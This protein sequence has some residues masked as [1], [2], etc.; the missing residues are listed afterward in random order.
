[1]EDSTTS[2][3]IVIRTMDVQ[4][5]MVGLNE[6]G[7]LEIPDFKLNYAITRLNVKL[8]GLDKAY[9]KSRKALMDAHVSVDERGMYVYNNDVDKLFVFKSI[10]D[11]DDYTSAINTLNETEITDITWTIKASVLK[12]IKGLKASTMMRINELIIDDVKL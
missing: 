2:K 3:G 10:K 7:S 6:L 9:V 11:K 8:A 1:M 5:I 4:R 12:E